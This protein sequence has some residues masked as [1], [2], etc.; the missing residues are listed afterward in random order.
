MSICFLI[1]LRFFIPKDVR[2]TKKTAVRR[3]FLIELNQ[4]I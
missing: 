2:I 4:I 3:F 1:F